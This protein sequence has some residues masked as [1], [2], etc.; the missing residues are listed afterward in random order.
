M[1]RRRALKTIAAAGQE[2]ALAEEEGQRVVGVAVPFAESAAEGRYLFPVR[3][4]RDVPVVCPDHDASPGVVVHEPCDGLGHVAVT[5]G[6]HALLAGRGCD[7]P[8]HQV[9]GADQDPRVFQS[10]VGLVTG[11]RL[12]DVVRDEADDLLGAPHQ[13]LVRV[14]KRARA[15][16]GQYVQ[17]ADA[18]GLIGRRPAQKGG[19]GLDRV[20]AELGVRSHE[21]DPALFG[22]VAVVGAQPL[23][24]VDHLAGAP[25]PEAQPGDEPF[26]CARAVPNVRVER[27]GG[28][29]AGLHGEGGEPLLTDQ[30]LHDAV[31]QPEELARA[32]GGFPQTDDPC[33]PQGLAQGFQVLHGRAGGQGAQGVGVLVQPPGDVVGHRLASPPRVR[34]GGTR[35]RPGLSQPFMGQFLA[36]RQ[37]SRIS[38]RSRTASGRTCSEYTPAMLTTTSSSPARSY[39]ASRAAMFPGGPWRKTPESTRARA[40]RPGRLWWMRRS[41]RRSMSQ[42]CGPARW[43]RAAAKASR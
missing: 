17:G 10:L 27:A 15:G 33:P 3:A 11:T 34:Q 16:P 23:D 29:L 28:G 36:S 30:E 37:A 35:A 22:Q 18:P 31:L 41:V 6:V 26:G 43:T 14:G 13:C 20:R 9:G 7:G 42:Q 24:E 19:D 40:P 38:W 21:A 1:A 4:L 5:R 39:S 12:L 25:G 32:V 8:G 2:G